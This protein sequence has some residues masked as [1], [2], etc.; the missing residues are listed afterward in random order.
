M[1]ELRAIAFVGVLLFGYQA[2][3]GELT[4]GSAL[5]LGGAGLM[6]ALSGFVTARRRAGARRPVVRLLAAA[7]VVMSIAMAVVVALAL[8][9]LYLSGSM[10]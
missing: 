1:T 7:Y 5:G 8:K 3:L 6:L 2:V 10:R 9:W 4:P